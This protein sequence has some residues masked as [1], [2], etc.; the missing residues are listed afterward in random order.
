MK[1]ETVYPAARFTDR[2]AWWFVLCV[3]DDGPFEEG[4]E[5]M[6]D[7]H[8]TA[9]YHDGRPVGGVH[10]QRYGPDTGPYPV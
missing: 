5:R 9:A 8:M 10:I 1:T 2:A 4:Y 6:W 3:K 7:D